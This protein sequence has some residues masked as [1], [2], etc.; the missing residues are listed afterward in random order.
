MSIN[1]IKSLF[2]FFLHQSAE[3]KPNLNLKPS[4]TKASAQD[5]PWRALSESR[6]KKQ[7]FTVRPPISTGIFYV[8]SLVTAA[9][10]GALVGFKAAGVNWTLLQTAIDG[11]EIPASIQNTGAARP[12]VAELPSSSG[13]ARLLDPGAPIPLPFNFAKGSISEP[14]ATKQSFKPTENSVEKDEAVSVS[15]RSTVASKPHA[16]NENSVILPVR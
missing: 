14:L 4:M 15:L 8:V 5:T 16:E 7:K 3:S 1:R 10:L 9:S 2:S 11:S 13:Q 12:L 6:V